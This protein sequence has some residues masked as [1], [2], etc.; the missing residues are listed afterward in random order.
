M[1]RGFSYRHKDAK[2]GLM[3]PLEVPSMYVFDSAE[4]TNDFALCCLRD[5]ADYVVIGG[6]VEDLPNDRVRLTP[7]VV[8]G[9]IS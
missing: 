3:A 8:V 1:R 5:H 4:A 2:C 6:A 9:H 7:D